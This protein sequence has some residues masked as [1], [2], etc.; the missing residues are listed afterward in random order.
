MPTF[1]IPSTEWYSGFLDISHPDSM[2]RQVLALATN[3]V[4]DEFLTMPLGDPTL[5]QKYH[6][7]AAAKLELLEE[8]RTS[9]DEVHYGLMARSAETEPPLPG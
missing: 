6:I 1:K 2:F 9:L 3:D 4:K 7:Q 8:I 5:L